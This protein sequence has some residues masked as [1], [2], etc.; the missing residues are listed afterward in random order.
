MDASRPLCSIAGCRRVSRRRA[1]CGTHYERWRRTGTTDLPTA[2]G[3]FWAKVNKTDACWLW[4]GA[5]SGGTG[6]GSCT[7]QD[8]TRSS[9]HRMAF[10]LI[11]GE[12]PAGLVLDHLCRVRACVN[13]DH[14]EPVT[15][16][17]NI[18]RGAAP[19]AVSAAKGE[20][21]NGHPHDERNTYIRPSG[22]RDCRP[23]AAARQLARYH[24]RK[25]AS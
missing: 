11:R 6:Y 19:A 1:W 4:T 13:P 21:K 14:L 20:C 12:I 8:G 2:E 23:C 24:A 9:A 25:A 22:Q 3:R 18:R 15:H 7:G 5:I 17:E 10:T 16:R